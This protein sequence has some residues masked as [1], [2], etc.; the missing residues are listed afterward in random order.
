MLTSAIWKELRLL[1]DAIKN[2]TITFGEPEEI[3]SYREICARWMGECFENDILNL[4]QVMDQVEKKQ[5][6]LT[7]PVMI[8]PVTWDVHAFPAFFGGSVLGEDDVI[9]RVPSVQL[10]YFVTD[11]TKMQD[12]RFVC[13]YAYAYS[14]YWF[15][16]Y[17]PNYNFISLYIIYMYVFFRGA[18]WEETFLETVEKLEKNNTFQFIST[19][20][21]ASRTLDVELERNT[22]S[23]IPYFLITFITMTI[24]S[25]VTCMMTDWVRSKPMLGLLGNFSAVMGTMAAFGLAM[26]LGYDFIGMVLAAPFLTCSMY[27]CFYFYFTNS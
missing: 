24:F 20:R 13:F 22:R 21:F 3:F 2:M 25:V 7:F 4:D 23:V 26:Y 6:N 1:D 17:L 12:E 15:S 11:D 10:L 18:L 27:F 19:A 5:L 9:E 14:T 16:K 8:N